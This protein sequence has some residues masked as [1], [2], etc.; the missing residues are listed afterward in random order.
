MVVL[1]GGCAGMSATRTLLAESDPTMRR[2][3]EIRSELEVEDEATALGVK[4]GC[5]VCQW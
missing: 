1:S 5:P 2:C 3:E 4:G